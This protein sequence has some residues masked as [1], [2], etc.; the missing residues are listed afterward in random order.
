[1][2]VLLDTHTILWFSEN[3]TKLSKSAKTLIEDT[4]NRCYVSIASF[5]EIA[6]KVSLN[7]LQINLS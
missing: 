4:N 7:K 1:M 2:D 3:N 6:I 5:W